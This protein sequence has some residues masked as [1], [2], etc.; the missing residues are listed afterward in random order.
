[1]RRQGSLP[2]LE[3]GRVALRWTPKCPEVPE[4]PHVQ[5][6]RT[7][8]QRCP[9]TNRTRNIPAR[10]RRCCA[11]RFQMIPTGLPDLSKSSRVQ[12]NLRKSKKFRG[13]ILKKIRKKIQNDSARFSWIPGSEPVHLDLEKLFL[14]SDSM[15]NLKFTGKIEISEPEKNSKK[16]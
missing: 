7:S 10:G 5:S 4:Q 6:C 9:N 16:S 1:M 12:K 3:D 15:E 13:K 11:Q 14:L 2:N 8:V